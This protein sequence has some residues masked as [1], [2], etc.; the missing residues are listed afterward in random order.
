[1]SFPDSFSTARLI[2]ERLTAA[3]WDDVRAMDSDTQ[4]MALLGGTRDDTQTKAYFD[5]NL[6]HWDQYGFGLWVLREPGGRLAGRAAIRHLDV[7]GTDEVELGYGFFPE[8]WRR[9][10][11]TEIATEL[12][13]LGRHELRLPTLVAI[14]RHANI[15]SQR[16]LTKIGLVYER[17]IVE[18]GVVH[19]LFRSTRNDVTLGI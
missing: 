3:H 15:G 9:G 7:E 10:L 18:E 16:V 17:D 11:A 5:K 8:Y 19:M 2:A 6:R 12:L 4:F 14:T 1:V 13:R